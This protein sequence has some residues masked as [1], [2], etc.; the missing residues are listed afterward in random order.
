MNSWKKSAWKWRLVDGL[1]PVIA[2]YPWVVD[3]AVLWVVYDEA[4]NTTTDQVEPSG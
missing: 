1:A 2:I 4:H 3:L